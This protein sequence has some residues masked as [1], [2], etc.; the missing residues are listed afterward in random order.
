MIENPLV[1]QVPNDMT[2][3]EISLELS[4]FLTTG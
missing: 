4:M 3:Q 1:Q 2:V